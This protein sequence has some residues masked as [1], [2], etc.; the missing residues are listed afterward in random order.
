MEVREWLDSDL[1]VDIWKR[2][3]QYE[4]ETFD[5]WLDRVSSG[6]SE[7]RQLIIDK[8]FLFAGR[9]LS[10]RGLQNKGRK[11]TFSNCYVTT[12]PED[13]IESIFD[14]AKKLA[15]TF[16]YGGG[17]GVDI[18]E[19]RPKGAKVN[20]AAKSTSG[21]CSFMDL[22]S[23]VTEVIG[24][25]GRRGALMISIDCSHPDIEEFI[26][27]KT[28][29]NKV[30]KANISIKITDDFM[31]AV[32]NKD[33]YWLTYYVE[34]TNETIAK[35]VDAQELFMKLAK[36]NWDYAEPGVLFWDNICNWNLLS[37]DKD[38]KYAGTNPCAEEPLPAGGSCLLGSINL[39]EFVLNPFTDNA[40][41]DYDGFK[42]TVYIAVIALN[43]VLDE[44]LPLHPLQEQQDSVRDWRQIGL[45]V[46]G[47]ADMLIKLGI[48]YGSEES[49]DLS[50]LIG[51]TM[52]D[53]AIRQSALLA[54]SYGTYLK[55][56][57]DKVLS[58]KFFEDNTS[59]KTK[60]LVS[61]WGLRNSQLLTIAPTG[62]ISTMLGI[63][64]GVEPIYAYSYERRTI[65][66]H[67]KEVIY[68]V[69][70]PIVDKYMKSMNIDDESKLPEFFTNAM[71][72]NPL[73]RV[74]IQGTWQKSIDASISS[75]VNLANNATIK[76][77]YDL[78]ISAWENGLKGLTIFRDGCSRLGILTTNNEVEDENTD[79]ELTYEKLPWGTTIACS[80]DLIGKKRKIMSGCGAIHVQAWFEP[81]DGRCMEV[82]LSKGSSGGCN[83]F[84][85]A[86]SR[87]TSYAL[88]T[89][90]NFETTIDQLKSTPTCPSYAVRT[91][92]Q[93][94]TSKGNC[95]P[96]AL[97]N[98]LVEMQTEIYDE[99]GINEDV[100]YYVKPFEN[101][102]VVK[103]NKKHKC[104]ECGEE[105]RFEGGCNSCP[106]CGYS[107]CQ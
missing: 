97:A 21:A 1:A 87:M 89:G 30:T 94:D 102:K 92:T 86:L 6:D 33:K 91:A 80:D 100:V 24:Q 60:A 78:Y 70:T 20:N 32:I 25:N 61:Q 66:L 18:S 49:L 55:Y 16:S 64:G 99:L 38:F 12:P 90:A 44:G 26:D 72:L 2:K 39:S 37:E 59:Q 17:I 43:D 45:G 10:N 104:P 22:Y 9:I 19:L 68:K 48:K 28:D 63:S 101:V 46:M 74:K 34:D 31:K 106:S 23:M 98:A 8:K 51:F 103:E 79:D 95:C 42:N 27:I 93:K 69:Y 40:T 77:V 105:L 47:I 58:S 15:R 81:V 62:S 76:D 56:N 29:L 96:T 41:F 82:F 36:N 57:K 7:L 85:T 53:A 75:T 83:S 52:I 54:K 84:M 65:S 13:N 67:D 11:V 14:V 88:R 3:Y 5:E 71:L 4:D 35:E 73:D 107:K 50:N